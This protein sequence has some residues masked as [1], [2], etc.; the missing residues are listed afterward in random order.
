MERIKS[1]G[2]YPKVVLL[3][4]VVMVL[5]FTVL[6]SVTASRKG[7]AYQDE[8]LIPTQ[9]NGNTVYS[10]EIQGEQ[11][12]FT[13]SADKAVVFQYGDK[14][15]G[16]YTAKDDAT[17]IPDGHEG[18]AGV[19]LRCG[20]EVVFRGGVWK[21]NGFWWIVNEDGSV[22]VT[23]MLV[24]TGNGTVTDENG[25]IIDPMEPPVS[26][27]LDL[28]AGPELTHKAVWPVWFC[29]VFACLVTAIS[30]LFADEMF[31]LHLIFRIRG[32]E[33]AEPSDWEIASRFI[34]WTIMPVF[35]LML[36]IVGLLI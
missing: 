15:Y 9:E 28:M 36:F 16:P 21:K 14:L 4:L 31:R 17:A 8:I 27:I 2:R 10:G 20:E 1:L 35:A 19:E 24:V 6:Y 30:M 32:A 7:F 18:M 34:V 13:V 23:D 5:A 12:V 22:A 25:N 33:H 26:T 29:G 11:S 3:V